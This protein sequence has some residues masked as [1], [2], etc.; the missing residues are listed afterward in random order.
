MKKRKNKRVKIKV[1]VSWYFVVLT[2]L[3]IPSVYLVIKGSSAPIWGVIPLTIQPFLQNGNDVLSG[4]SQSYICS[5]IFYIVVNYLPERKRQ[6][7]ENRDFLFNAQSYMSGMHTAI[8]FGLGNKELFCQKLYSIPKTPYGFKAPK[9]LEDIEKVLWY[10]HV[11]IENSY[12][13]YIGQKESSTEDN[14]IYIKESLK[15]LHDYADEYQEYSLKIYR[16]M[17]PDIYKNNI[18]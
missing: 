8:R 11:Q 15:Q 16:F 2:V 6:V 18:D 4:I 14:G 12:N 1:S 5:Y 17:H 3:L 7:E 13:V 9:G 10:K